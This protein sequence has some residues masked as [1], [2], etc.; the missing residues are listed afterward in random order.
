MSSFVWGEVNFFVIVLN[1]EL[2]NN[3]K[4]LPVSLLFAQNDR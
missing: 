2:H 3:I 4:A 1:E